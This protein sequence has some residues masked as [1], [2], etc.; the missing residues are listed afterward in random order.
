[1]LQVLEKLKEKAL[2][3]AEMT[4]DQVSGLIEERHTARKNKDFAKSDEIRSQLT[5][6]GISLMDLPSGTT[7]WR[8]C[9]REGI[10]PVSGHVVSGDV[11]L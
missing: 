7:T 9:V 3:R 8:P 6:K 2:K 5:L 4:E 1:M 10:D 11:A